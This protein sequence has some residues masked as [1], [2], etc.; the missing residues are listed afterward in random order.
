MGIL[1]E[2]FAYIQ[3]VL[4]KFN[5][6]KAYPLRTPMVI[7]ALENDTYSFRLRQEGEAVLGTEY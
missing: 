2:Q 7:R 5:I 6:D 1:V 3:K 4:E